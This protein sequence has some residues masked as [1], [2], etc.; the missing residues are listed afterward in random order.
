MLMEQRRRHATSSRHRVALAASIRRW[1]APP[2]RRE[3]FPG[4]PVAPFLRSSSDL[5]ERVATGLEQ[6]AVRIEAIRAVEQL[7][8]DVRPRM[9][10]L[11]RAV[12][13]VESS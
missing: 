5:A 12:F 13:L 4:P 6:G 11:R 2:R 9:D 10:D 8:S 7:L 1:L 3:R